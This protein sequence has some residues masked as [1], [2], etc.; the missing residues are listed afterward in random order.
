[1]APEILNSRRFDS[2]VDLYSSGVIL[3]EMITGKRPFTGKTFIELAINQNKPLSLPRRV[4]VSEGC[5]AVLRALLQRKPA[6]RATAAQVLGMP[7]LRKVSPS[8]TPDVAV[9]AVHTGSGGGGGSS[10]S[11]GGGGAL[12]TAISTATGSGSNPLPAIAEM[13]ESERTRYNNG[14]DQS[15]RGI[16][17]TSPTDYNP[18]SNGEIENGEGASVVGNEDDDE[19]E[20]ENLGDENRKNDAAAEENS[21]YQPALPLPPLDPSLDEWEL[22]PSGDPWNVANIEQKI[23]EVLR[24]AAPVEAPNQSLTADG[25]KGAGSTGI[26]REQRASIDGVREVMDMCRHAAEQAAVEGSESLGNRVMRMLQD[27][28]SEPA[29]DSALEEAMEQPLTRLQSPGESKD[30]CVIEDDQDEDQTTSSSS[31]SSPPVLAVQA[32]PQPPSVPPPPNAVRQHFVTAECDSIGSNPSSNASVAE[33]IACSAC[34]LGSSGGGGGFAPPA[35]PPSEENIA[36]LMSM[37]FARPA[38]EAALRFAENDVQIAADR[39]L[40]SS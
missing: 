23:V 7:W 26:V 21:Q 19:N 25:P 14:P 4:R 20:V 24:A 15:K 37:G 16:I 28:L 10:G 6:K 34:T 22:V 18:E 9:G 5:L 39:L 17:A 38:V 33:E 29:V 30:G 27:F 31:L 13:P 11:C 36:Q 8:S 2:K 12:L 3:F 32:E 40:A 1:M 35:A